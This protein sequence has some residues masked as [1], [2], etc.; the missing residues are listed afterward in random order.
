MGILK[1]KK[2]ENKEPQYYMSST[3]IRTLNY[4]VYYM[5]IVE[6]I[7]YFL[8]AFAV[9]A[10]CGYLFYGGIGKDEFGDPTQIT[11][12]LNIVIPS[13]VGCVTGYLFL[14]IRVNQI[15]DKRRR[16]IKTQFRDMLE[17]L[18]TSLNSGKNVTDAFLAV[19][20]DL[21]MQYDEDAFIQNELRVI[22]SG[23]RMTITSARLTYF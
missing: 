11:K 12:I 18:S 19:Q 10:A 14:P 23:I 2:E 21:S 5:S 1:K 15:I 13:I 7:I 9:G 17:S 16:M 3:N 4:K 20:Q 6:K 22:I 8:L